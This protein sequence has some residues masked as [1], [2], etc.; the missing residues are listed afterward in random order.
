MFAIV[1]R[2]L[3]DNQPLLSPR[4]RVFF[5]METCLGVDVKQLHWNFPPPRYSWGDKLGRT[6][7]GLGEQ[8]VEPDCTETQYSGKLGH[9]TCI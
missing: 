7:M 9:E 5:L 4:Y 8:G 2:Q 3:L 6:I 1:G